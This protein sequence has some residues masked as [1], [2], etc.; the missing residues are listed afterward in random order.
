MSYMLQKA[1]LL[2]IFH[3]NHKECGI[4][5]PQLIPSR[6]Y[7]SFLPVTADRVFIGS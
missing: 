4:F 6:F 2:M 1:V 7:S 3:M 5:V